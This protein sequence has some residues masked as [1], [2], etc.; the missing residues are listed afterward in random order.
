MP[1]TKENARR[2]CAEFNAAPVG[3]MVPVRVGPDL[4]AHV[5]KHPGDAMQSTQAAWD[6]M[7]DVSSKA[8]A[9]LNARNKAADEAQLKREA[10]TA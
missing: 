8:I 2:F 5:K 9:H 10:A 6:F 3:S 7:R 1:I 4:I